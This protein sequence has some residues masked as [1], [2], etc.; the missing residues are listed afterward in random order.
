L[1][2]EHVAD[3]DLVHEILRRWRAAGRRRLRKGNGGEQSAAG[4]EDQSFFMMTAP[5]QSG[6]SAAQPTK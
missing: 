4:G 1:N 6:F 2:L 5:K 3:R